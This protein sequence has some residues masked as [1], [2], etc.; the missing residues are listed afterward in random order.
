[1]SESFEFTSR[2]G[3]NLP[4]PELF[5]DGQC[6]GMGYIPIHEDDKEEPW[7]TLWKETYPKRYSFLGVV[8]SLF[9]LPVWWH[10]KSVIVDLITKGTA[11][12]DRYVFVE[13]PDCSG[14]GNK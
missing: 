13:C 4:D 3:D 1:M 14:T 6:E 7:A 10:W 12:P 8:K 9:K 5:C 2:Y 11:C